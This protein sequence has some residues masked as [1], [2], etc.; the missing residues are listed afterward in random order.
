MGEI[1]ERYHEH[2]RL[3]SL[4]IQKHPVLGSIHLNFCQSE[5][6]PLALYTSVIIGA[7]GIGKS[8]LLRSLAEIFCCLESLYNGKDATVPQYYFDLK[9]SSRWEDM[10]FANYRDD[11][12]VE[13]GRS[14]YTQFV[15]RKNGEEV[16]AS[17]MEL[18]KRVI[19]S[20]T[21][22][23]DKYV[24]KSTEMYRYK[25][26]RNENSP[27]TT[28]TRT[29]VRKTVESLLGSL[30]MKY[31]FRQELK[32]LL[33]HIGL[34]PKLELSYSMRYKDVFVTEDISVGK[35]HH[36][37]EHQGD[38]FNKR[39]SE[40][41]GTR[42]FNKIK[43]EEN[44]KLDEVAKFLQ[45]LY[46]RGFDDMRNHLVY[47]L[48]SE[49]DSRVL[50]DKEALKVLSK[51]D[52]LSYPSLKVFK[53]N[54]NYEFDQSSSGESS[55]LCQMVSIMSDIEPNSLV[56]IDE[57]E[58]SSHP[59]WQINYIGWMKNIFGRYYNCHFV[60]STHSHFLLTDLEPNTSDIVAL[61]K[62]YEGIVRDV[63]EGVNTFNWSVDDILYE[64]FRIR[65]KKNEALERDLER[66]IQL[67]EEKGPVP[68]A[69]IDELLRRFNNV[70]RGDRDPLGRFIKE[71]EAYAKSRS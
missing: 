11:N 35:L 67:M 61:D 37:F 46:H 36:I 71:V 50:E 21:T 12:A 13:Q 40:V 68:Q 5:T 9:Y 60:I 26:L 65:N 23:A 3:Q 69:E 27:S 63:S 49:N 28:G 44:W 30:D 41:W 56:L 34:Q 29:M 14:I 10:E 17:S 33:E 19:A 70:Y 7:N 20:S 42:N 51:L 62:N 1:N 45:R 52:L 43:E 64:V 59:N 32:D 39:T 22:I 6:D 4:T 2:F 55:L 48:L 47:D 57:P 54:T 8:Y 38:Y 58:T 16:R 25:G 24:A 15:Y 53:Y 31:G 66:A 18:P